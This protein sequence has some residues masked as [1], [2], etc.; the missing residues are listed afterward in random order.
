MKSFTKVK[1][2]IA[3]DAFSCEKGVGNHPMAQ[4]IKPNRKLETTMKQT[5]AQKLATAQTALEITRGNEERW[6]KECARLRGELRKLESACGDYQSQLRTAQWEL[7]NVMGALR[8]AR[9]DA[10]QAVTVTVTVT[11]D[12]VTIAR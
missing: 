12:S 10:A 4:I 11:K 8:T 5:L 2:P 1:S 6:E 3:L 9:M 7:S